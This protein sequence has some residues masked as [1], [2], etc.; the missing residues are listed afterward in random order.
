VRK[1]TIERYTPPVMGT[2]E[3]ANQFTWGYE[4]ASKVS[5]KEDLT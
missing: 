3:E 4:K 1:A 2:D 5:F